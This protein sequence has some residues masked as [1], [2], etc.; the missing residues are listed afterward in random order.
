MGI[1]HSEE[2][3]CQWV[4]V[5]QKLQRRGGGKGGGRLVV[6][7]VMPMVTVAEASTNR[8]LLPQ[9]LNL[10]FN[11]LQRRS[12]LLRLEGQEL[13][14]RV[15]VWRVSEVWGRGQQELRVTGQQ[16]RE[17]IGHR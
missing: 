14:R 7:V 12:W 8:Q 16:R 3:L 4:V 17:R 6:V 5:G 15:E 1:G 9:K 10:I 11:S 2:L 13:S